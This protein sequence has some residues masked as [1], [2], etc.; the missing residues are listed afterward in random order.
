MGQLS[1][2]VHHAID[3]L[4]IMLRRHNFKE[5]EC[6][7]CKKVRHIAKARKT[8]QNKMLDRNHAK[9]LRRRTHYVDDSQGSELEE[10]TPT[11][12]DNSYN[13]FTITMHS[14]NP[15][16][17]QVTINQTSVQMELDT[18]AS[19]SGINKQTFDVI[20]DHSHI[21]MRTTDVHLKT[22]TGEALKILGNTDVSVNYGEEKQ[23]LVVYVCC[24]WE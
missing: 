19:L 2:H 7:N 24:C 3:V 1:H 20:A 4:E 14:Q 10:H 17:L 11:T 9:E 12:T 6:Y 15:I 8:K 23:Q 16:V 18:G 13:L 5:T 22:H 21:T